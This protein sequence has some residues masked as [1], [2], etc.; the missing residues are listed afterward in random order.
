MLVYRMTEVQSRVWERGGA[1]AEA[2]AQAIAER[3]S[4]LIPGLL[5]VESAGGCPAFVVEGGG[6]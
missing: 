6:Q 1:K 5:L 2:L 4:P 3:L